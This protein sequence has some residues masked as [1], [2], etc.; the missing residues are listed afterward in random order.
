MNVIKTEEKVI[1]KDI[2]ENSKLIKLDENNK[3]KDK[4]FFKLVKEK[5][6]SLTGISELLTIVLMIVVSIVIVRNSCVMNKTFSEL[7]KE[8]LEKSVEQL[9]NVYNNMMEDNPNIKDMYK[10]FVKYLEINRYD[11][12]IING[13]LVLSTMLTMYAITGK[14]KLSIIFTLIF[15]SIIDIANYVVFDL[16]GTPIAFADIYSISTAMAVADG[17]KVKFEKRFCIYIIVL[18][19]TLF[20]VSII[21]FKKNKNKKIRVIERVLSIFLVIIIIN[22]VLN[23]ENF[24]TESYWNLEE[25]YRQKGIAR[26]LLRQILDINIKKPEGYSLEKVNVILD[27]YEPQIKDEEK[28]NV[29]I[30]INESFSDLNSTYNLGIEDNMP[31]LHSLTG[32]VIKGT[33]YSS[34]YGGSTATAEW[35]FMTGN[36]AAFIPPNSIPLLVYIRDDKDTIFSE[37]IKQNY[38]TNS[39]HSYY[40]RCYNRANTYAKL[41]LENSMFVED[42]KDYEC[43]RPGYPTDSDTYKNMIK[44]YENRDKSKRFLGYILTMQNHTAYNTPET[45]YKNK[46]YVEGNYS[47]DQYLSLVND[48]DK[49]LKEFIDYFSKEQEKTVLLFFGDH[50]PKID[51]EHE[52]NEWLITQQVPY[53]LWTNFDIEEKEGEDISFN[54]LSTLIYEYAGL[55]T[56]KYV[57]FLKDLKSDI[58]IY[59]AKGYKDKD[60][61]I[62]NIDDETSPYYEKIKEYKIL[63][64]YF[65]FDK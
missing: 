47:L 27:G 29:F 48:S 63:Q 50:Q 28:V 32:N 6:K 40:K 34:V 55:D 59:T 2:S 24:K 4:S 21:K 19:L 62:Y 8:A 54:Y 41:G 3:N 49:A 22:S 26:G 5:Y 11:V 9:G 46:G 20:T 31:Y 58:P 43:S 52:E 10:C 65:M 7:N 23:I 12:I 51:F 15:W 44:Q 53:L 25:N 13:A 30:I 39:L 37:A 36:S 18:V 60:G 38:S 17:M 42:M 64:Y 33:A 61:K 1:Q 14:P 35:E 57:E 56:N 16:R 45:F